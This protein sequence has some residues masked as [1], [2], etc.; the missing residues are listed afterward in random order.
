MNREFVL[1]IDETGIGVTQLRFAPRYAMRNCRA[2]VMIK[3]D[4]RQISPLTVVLS[5]R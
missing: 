2:K 4:C 1:D 3:I 5:S